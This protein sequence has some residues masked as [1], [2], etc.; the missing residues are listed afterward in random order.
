MSELYD[1]L[2]SMT[3]DDRT[4]LLQIPVYQKA[5]LGMVIIFSIVL[6]S[7]MKIFIYVNMADENWSERPINVLIVIDMVST[8]P[9][10]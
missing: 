6:G 2:K 10:A 1:F 7:F 3:E 5:L 8:V 4:F 9:A